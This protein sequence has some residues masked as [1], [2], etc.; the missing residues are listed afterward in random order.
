MVNM[1]HEIGMLDC[2]YHNIQ[3]YTCVWKMISGLTSSSRHLKLQYFA[4][5]R[6]TYVVT[7][8]SK[9]VISSVLGLVLMNS[10]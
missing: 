9:N 3:A 5:Y 1:K 10:K 4:I 7:S 8:S 6:L 2:K